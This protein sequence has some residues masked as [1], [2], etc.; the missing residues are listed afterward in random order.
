[1][2]KNIIQIGGH[3]AVL[4][5]D[6]DTNLLRGEF[7]GLNGGADFYGQSVDELMSEGQ[8][9]LDV[10]L[11]VCRERGINPLKSFSGKFQLRLRKATHER[12]TLAAAARGVSLNTLIEEAVEHELEAIA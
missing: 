1:M 2:S 3:Q 8:R 9:S 7:L 12:A 10:F 5:Y 11:E 4:S 6:P